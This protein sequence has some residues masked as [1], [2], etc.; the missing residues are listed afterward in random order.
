MRNRPPAMRIKSRPDTPCPSKV[1]SGRVSLT[2]HA[3]LRSSSTRV[4][5][6]PASPSFRALGCSGAGSLPLKIEM[7]MMLS[8]PSTISSALSVSSPIQASG[9]DSH[10]TRLPR[11]WTRTWRWKLVGESP[12]CG[13]CPS[14]RSFGEPRADHR[15][16]HRSA[17]ENCV[18]ELAVGHLLRVDELFV[19]RAKLETARHVGGLIERRIAAIKRAPHLAL[20]VRTLERNSVDQ[21]L[22]GLLG[23]HLSEMEVEREDDSRAPVHAPEQRTHP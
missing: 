7:K 5:N 8:M 11:H 9:S 2:I 13:A 6:A 1:K 21:K 16:R 12:R 19:Q 3:M 14:E 18:V 15:D 17:L 4:M 10:S 22:N 23:R 20:G